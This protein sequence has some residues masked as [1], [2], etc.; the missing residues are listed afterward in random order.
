MTL[1]H[2]RE[3]PERLGAPPV[4][5]P[6]TCAA[7]PP[8]PVRRRSPRTLWSR[9]SAACAASSPQT[10]SS[11]CATQRYCRAERAAGPHAMQCCAVQ[12]WGL[13]LAGGGGAH[14]ACMLAHACHGLVS[15]AHSDAAA[16]RCRAHVHACGQRLSL[17]STCRRWRG[18]EAAPYAGLT[19]PRAAPSL[20][21]S[22]RCCRGLLHPGLPPAS[23]ARQPCSF[24]QHAQQLLPQ[25]PLPMGARPSQ[26]L[27]AQL[28]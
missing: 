17:P 13:E 10:S 6:P 7:Y 21:G 18:T 5:P 12:V 4:P 3:R 26:P 20:I 25:P 14:A 24:V 19:S 8:V 9:A 11:S 28:A 23:H 16:S 15:R 27:L 1:Q 2:S 22:G